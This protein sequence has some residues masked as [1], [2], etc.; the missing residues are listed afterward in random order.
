M[1]PIIFANRPAGP[2]TTP[3]A[4][5]RSRDGRPTGSPCKAP[6][7][8]QFPWTRLAYRRGSASAS[9]STSPTPTGVGVSGRTPR[10][11]MFQRPGR[12]RSSNRDT[13]DDVDYIVVLHQIL[14]V[15]FME[16]P[17]RNRAS[18]LAGLLLA[19]AVSRQQSNILVAECQMQSNFFMVETQRCTEAVIASGW[20]AIVPNQSELKR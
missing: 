5:P 12:L 1:L 14:R 3:R 11:S 8:S 13:C 2:M 6:R 4:S 9:P 19:R 15:R 10:G 17:H 7:N 16:G 18:A 20:S